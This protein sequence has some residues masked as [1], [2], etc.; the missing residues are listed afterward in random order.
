M[1]PQNC[2]PERPSG[3]C[4]LKKDTSSSWGQDFFDTC[5]PDVNTFVESMQSPLLQSATNCSQLAIEAVQGNGPKAQSNHLYYNY[6]YNFNR[7]VRAFPDRDM[8]VVR[9]EML[10]DDMRSIEK[11][12]GGDPSRKFEHEGPVITHGSEK[13]RYKAALDSSLVPSLCCT[14]P[15]EILVYVHVLHRAVNLDALQK[16][17]SIAALLSKCQANSLKSLFRQCNWKTDKIQSD[18]LR[19]METVG[20]FL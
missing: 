2:V 9:R 5:F 16:K 11:L 17:S 19:T 8:V 13:F 15:N 7:T 18:L 20:V 12:L 10:W 1:N 3:A 4:N 6:H 14:I